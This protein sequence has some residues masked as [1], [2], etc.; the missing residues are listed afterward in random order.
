MNNDN[1]KDV[2]KGANGEYKKEGI[3]GYGGQGDVYLCKEINSKRE[4][5][6]VFLIIFNI[7]CLIGD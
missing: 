3:I 6:Y 4:Y 7:I 5:E 2:Y 1:C